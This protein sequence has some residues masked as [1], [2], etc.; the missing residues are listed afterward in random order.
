MKDAKNA[1]AGE[2]LYK[3]GRTISG[4]EGVRNVIGGGVAALGTGTAAVAGAM[5]ARGVNQIHLNT[6][7]GAINIPTA[8]VAGI[9]ALVGASSG[10]LTMGL[11]ALS[12]SN[13]NK[14]R[15]YNNYRIRAK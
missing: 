9:G 12:K 5:K 15:A 2:A 6:K 7:V 11:G 4:A 8:T 10:I 1:D 3:K 13:D 14:I